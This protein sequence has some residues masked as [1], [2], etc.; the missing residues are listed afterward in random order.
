M[1]DKMLALSE[2]E[3]PF[4]S[5]YP[6]FECRFS[7]TKEREPRSEPPLTLPMY[8]SATLPLANIE[9]KRKRKSVTQNSIAKRPLVGAYIELRKGLEFHS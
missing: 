6:V 9:Q 4:L 7:Q 1:S 5:S 2:K 3:A 8:Q